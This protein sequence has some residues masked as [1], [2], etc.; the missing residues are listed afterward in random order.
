VE[1]V[2]ED[3][4]KV[5]QQ[6]SRGNRGS[7]VARLWGVLRTRI[8]ELAR[9]YN[10]RGVLQRVQEKL[11][12]AMEDFERAI[13][14]LRHPSASPSPSASTN[15]LA[16]EGGTP[17]RVQATQVKLEV[18]MGYS[19]NTLEA[20]IRTRLLEPG[21]RRPQAVTLAV[22][23]RNRGYARLAQANA[24]AAVEDFQKCAELYTQLVE[25]DGEGDLAPQYARSLTSLAWLYA[26]HPDNSLRDGRK[27]REYALKA[28]QVSEW[29][30]FLPV[31]TLAA[32]YAESGDFTNAIKWQEMTL[33]LA[34]EK[35]RA[36]FLARWELYKAGKPY[37]TAP[38]KNP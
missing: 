37:R 10:N 4:R 35:Y 29:K 38:P 25:H 13:Q 33:Q 11:A 17:A 30:T 32:A 27:A 7:E 18:A 23:L 1:E 16:A 6:A 5:I 20:L 36:E 28:C 19:E 14:T 12:P 24:N 21:A 34:P 31:A 15:R 2:V 8:N 22:A 3:A 9:T 26:T